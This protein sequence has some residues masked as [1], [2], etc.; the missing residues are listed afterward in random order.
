MSKAK[1][2]A[3]AAPTPPRGWQNAELPEFNK[4]ALLHSAW[5][6]HLTEKTE[7]KDLWKAD[8]KKRLNPDQQL[9]AYVLITAQLSHWRQKVRYLEECF[10]DAGIK[11]PL[12]ARVFKA[13]LVGIDHLE[14][15]GGPGTTQ[16]D[17]LAH[18]HLAT[19][20]HRAFGYDGKSF[21]ELRT[22]CEIPAAKSGRARIY[23]FDETMLLLK[24]RLARKRPDKTR[25][26]E[27]AEAIW[28]SVKPSTDAQRR[29]ALRHVLTTTGAT[30]AERAKPKPLS[31]GAILG[32]DGKV[33]DTPL[34]PSGA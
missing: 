2:K 6:K 12:P 3:S 20:L 8:S 5:L 18:Q 21:N 19:D 16:Y 15:F 26:R 27:I 10:N 13:A 28:V 34:P 17:W 32:Y 1:T 11:S 33:I 24:E 25:R 29:Q 23:N 9:A 31:H 30:C 22:A 14:R 4:I 7:H